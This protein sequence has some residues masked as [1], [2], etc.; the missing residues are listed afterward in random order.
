MNNLYK[1]QKKE[2]LTYPKNRCFHLKK[3]EALHCLFQQRPFINQ[4]RRINVLNF[5]VLLFARNPDLIKRLN[6]LK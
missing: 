1:E 4:P 6:L 2:D 3:I 5:V